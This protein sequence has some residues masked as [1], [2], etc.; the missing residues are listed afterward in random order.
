MEDMYN[1]DQAPAPVMGFTI[2]QAHFDAFMA[3]EE[4]VAPSVSMFKMLQDE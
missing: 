2:A 3:G 4:R 1:E